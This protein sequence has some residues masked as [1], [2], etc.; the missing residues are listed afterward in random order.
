MNIKTALRDIYGTLLDEFG[1]QNWW[2]AKSK[3]E[4]ERRIEIAI[5][6]ILTQNTS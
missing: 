2:P 4:E 5:G 1:K 3:L 6:A